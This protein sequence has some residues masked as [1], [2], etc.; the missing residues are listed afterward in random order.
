MKRSLSLVL[1][2]AL[3]T[4]VGL[5][6]VA[7]AQSNECVTVTI[8]YDMPDGSQ[9]AESTTSCPQVASVEAIGEAYD[10]EGFY[11]GAIFLYGS[12]VAEVSA[13]AAQVISLAASFDVW[14][15]FTAV[16]VIYVMVIETVLYY[17]TRPPT[18]EAQGMVSCEGG[19]CCLP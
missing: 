12:S 7:Q 6:S 3:L 14:V 2:F 8:Y 9:W 16:T 1:C 11:L 4:F 15:V 10:R 19:M 17:Q 13:Q 18:C 5:Q